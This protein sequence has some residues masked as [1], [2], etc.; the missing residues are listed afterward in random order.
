MTEKRYKE[1]KA[2]LTDKKWNAAELAEHAEKLLPEL[3]AGIDKGSFD[4]EP[5]IDLP[6]ATELVAPGEPVTEVTGERQEEPANQEE[7]EIEEASEATEADA[8]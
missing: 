8:E 2:I 7:Q 4:E 5:V 3:F 6:K 1:I